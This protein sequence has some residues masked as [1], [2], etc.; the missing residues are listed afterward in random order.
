MVAEN[1]SEIERLLD[2]PLIRAWMLTMPSSC[3][4]EFGLEHPLGDGAYGLLD[5]IPTH[6]SQK[7]IATALAAVPLEVAHKYLLVGSPD[8]ILSELREFVDL[9][10]AHV[11]LWNITYL[12]DYDQMRPSYA[13]MD[14][15]AAELHRL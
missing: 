9:G 10:L 14:A 7:E 13:T 6:L 1:D 3:F 12:A 11:V 5:Y 2:S 15:L 8:Q 4:E